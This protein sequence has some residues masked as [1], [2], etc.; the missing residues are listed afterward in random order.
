MNSAVS[1]GPGQCYGAP[2]RFL[3]RRVE[4]IFEVIAAIHWAE[5][6]VQMGDDESIGHLSP[7]SYNSLIAGP[8]SV[9]MPCQPRWR[10]FFSRAV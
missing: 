3:E 2:A 8:P 1:V 10:E 6:G 5:A 7:T 4:G 9:W